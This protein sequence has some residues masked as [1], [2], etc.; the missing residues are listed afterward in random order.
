MVRGSA[1]GALSLA[2]KEEE[3]TQSLAPRTIKEAFGLCR[4]LLRSYHDS[5]R[6]SF[7]CLRGYKAFLFCFSNDFEEMAQ[8]LF[9]CH[10]RLPQVT[11]HLKDWC[12]AVA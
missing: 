1:Q 3:I 8:H 5:G 7:L 2:D 12:C 9:M 11:Q 4:A 10:D 6:H